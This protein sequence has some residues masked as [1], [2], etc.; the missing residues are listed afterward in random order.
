M[1]GRATLNKLPRGYYTKRPSFSK[2]GA[3]FFAG[4]RPLFLLA[5]RP[6]FC[7]LTLAAHNTTNLYRPQILRLTTL[8]ILQI[9]LWLPKAPRGEADHRIRA[10]PIFTAPD[11]QYT[12]KNTPELALGLTEE[13]QH[14]EKSR[15][16]LTR[17]C[18][19]ICVCMKRENW[20]KINST[21][22]SK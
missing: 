22:C 21:V 6:F 18:I 1:D 11:F 3:H 16:P 12:T 10:A 15:L 9:G 13:K 8:I 4:S 7:S 17:A 2:L 5:Y 20:S 19:Y 14:S